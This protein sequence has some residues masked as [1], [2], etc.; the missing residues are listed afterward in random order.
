MRSWVM[1]KLGL[2]D[3]PR[4]TLLKF[5]LFKPLF[6]QMCLKTREILIMLILLFQTMDKTREM[7]IMLIFWELCGWEGRPS[8]PQQK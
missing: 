1:A 3:G 8:P 2:V 4:L 7:L 5:S 6:L